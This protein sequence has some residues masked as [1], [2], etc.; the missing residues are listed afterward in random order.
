[1][2][3]LERIPSL[4]Y[5]KTHWSCKHS[6]GWED[7]GLGGHVPRPENA[8]RKSELLSRRRLQAKTWIKVNEN[9]KQWKFLN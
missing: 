8:Q 3:K 1:M 9:L 6:W 5:W 2:A 7:G 4:V